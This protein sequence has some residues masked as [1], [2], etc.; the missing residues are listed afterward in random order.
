MLHLFSLRS[1]LRVKGLGLADGTLPLRTLKLERVAK[2]EE[3]EIQFAL[4]GRVPEPPY[5][6]H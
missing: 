6:G 4:A 3:G 5:R 2:R 1:P